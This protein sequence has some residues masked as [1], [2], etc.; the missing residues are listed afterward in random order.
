[1]VD[2]SAHRSSDVAGQDG[3]MRNSGS[4][5]RWAGFRLLSCKSLSSLSFCPHPKTGTR[6][7]A[8]LAGPLWRLK[9]AKE[10]SG[11]GEGCTCSG[12]LPLDGNLNLD[13]HLLLE[14]PFFL[15]GGRKDIISP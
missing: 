4:G 15:R 13:G 8:H 1:M 10:P 3:T 11:A 7:P 12:L 2:H 5:L 14:V 6:R 9:W